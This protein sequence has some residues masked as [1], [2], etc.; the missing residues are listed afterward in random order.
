MELVTLSDWGSLFWLVFIVGFALSM[1][2]N[3]GIV[4]FDLSFKIIDFLSFLLT[5]IFFGI[6]GIF[7]DLP[8]VE[9]VEYKSKNTD[10]NIEDD[11]NNDN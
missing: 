2:Y 10:D 7:I 5:K 11:Y 6:L 3:W 9:S 8:E 1:G 4:F